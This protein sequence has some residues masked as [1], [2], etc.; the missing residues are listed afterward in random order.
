[1]TDLA[2]ELEHLGRRIERLTGEPAS[3]SAPITRF[4]R[5]VLF[6]IGWRPRT[7]IEAVEALV[8]GLDAVRH[9]PDARVV[10]AK[11]LAEAVDE[12]A[13]NVVQVERA[14]VINGKP[15]LAHAAWLRRCWELLALAQQALAD[16]KD[17]TSLALVTSRDRGQLLPPL[18]MGRARAGVDE[19]QEP[20]W[21]DGEPEPLAD[22]T[23]V[24]ELRL[25]TIDHLLAA[26]RE[27]DALLGRRRRLLDT[28]RQLLLETS[29]ALALD[30]EGVQ[31]RQQSI[32][33]QI[34]RLN[35]YEAAGLR[36]D[37]ALLHQARTALARGE[38]DRLFAALSVLRR[39]AVD[40]GDADV[41]TRTTLALER[42]TGRSSS[43]KASKAAEASLERS[44]DEVLGERVVAAIHAGYERAREREP[45]DEEADDPFLASMLKR[46]FAPGAERATLAH[47]LSVDGCF[48]VGGVLSPVRIQEEHVR[49]RLV[50]FPTQRL[51]LEPA[52][53]PH[54][55]PTAVIVDPRT[56]VLDLAA[57][58][59]LSRRFVRDE[60]STRPRTVMQGEVRVYV[61]DGST[62][63]LG[64]RA[65]MRDAILLAELATVLARLERPREHGRVVLYYQYFDEAL[66]P[67][68]RVDTPGGALEAIGD[69][70]ATPRGGGTDIEL[71]LLS[72]LRLVQTAK[73]GDAD[74]RRAQIVLI[75]DGEAAVDEAKVLAARRAIGD[76]PVGVSVIA[77]GLENLA[78]REIVAHQRARNERAF[79]HFVPDAYLEALSE[80]RIDDELVVH[81]PPAPVG[82]AR[83]TEA[84][85]ERIG[86]LLEELADLQRSRRDEALRDLD[87][88]DRDR[89][90]E[91][92]EV[93]TA[94]EGERARLEALHRDDIALE[95]RYQR[96]FP[97]L[98]GAGH[99]RELD[100][101]ALRRALP[102]EGTLERDD[103]D[104]VLVALASVAE[105]VET[106]GS[107]R[108]ARQADAVDMLERLLPDARISPARYQE[109][110]RDY[111]GAVEAALAAVHGAARSGLGWQL[112]DRATPAARQ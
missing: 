32:S 15:S 29:A 88:T 14:T 89:R 56:I 5:P 4:F 60:V 68:C 65:R 52:L 30:A 51:E 92:A 111:P 107:A 31:Q 109:I 44:A 105:V 93:D 36:P 61:L 10:A 6:R 96:W 86:P 20:E 59:L 35:R 23:R 100:P 101:R 45:S 63:M 66:G 22:P 7:K 37:V 83:A 41:A 112:D 90:I 9:D 79:Y 46:H 8:L 103:L 64:P 53:G 72:S 71:A 94:G 17:H 50:P 26:A 81:L 84:V 106:V 91:R 70:T 43:S 13:A 21:S 34:T 77:L 24:L 78:L 99:G 1:M 85:Q 73:E 97:P 57:G 104:A 67:V 58:R 95:R 48:E 54:D 74:L 11:L 75:T 47:A 40:M 28:A 19:A 69:V 27:E 82:G 18:A 98:I 110:L 102:P 62:S 42:L 39:R 33:R 87:R 55:L 25:D 108:L 2:Q 12:L 80:G 16:T 49:P 76:L 3:I 38:P